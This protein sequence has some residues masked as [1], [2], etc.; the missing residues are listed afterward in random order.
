M[1][2][3]EEGIIHAWLD[4]A[5]PAGEAAALEAHVAGCA[6]C[7]ALVAEARG[8]VAASSRIVGYLDV[9]P[10]N[11]IPAVPAKKKRNF[12]LQSPWPAAI[13]ATLVIGVGIVTTRDQRSSDSSVATLLKTEDAITATPE[14][15]REPP[16]ALPTAVQEQRAANPPARPRSAPVAVV[17]LPP[18]SAAVQKTTPAVSTAPLPAPPTV[19]LR[20]PASTAAGAMA[21][22][23]RADTRDSSLRETMNRAAPGS[24]RGGFVGIGAVGGA[25]RSVAGAA[26]PATAPAAARDFAMVD[27]AESEAMRAAVGC[28]EMNASTDVVPARFALTGDSSGMPGLLGVRYLD[29]DGRLVAPVIDLGWSTAGGRVVIR[30]AAGVTLL[31]LAKTGSAVVGESANGPRSGRVFS[32]SR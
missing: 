6:E 20:A 10:G 2:H 12:W 11:V 27:R 7:G 32:C 14:A 28:Y 15:L 21:A 22:D 16:T 1:Q 3:P 9:V 19:Q 31:T 25:A 8:L 26:A 4:G 24:G 18:A 13:A 5:L 23:A 17:E 30:N 29:A